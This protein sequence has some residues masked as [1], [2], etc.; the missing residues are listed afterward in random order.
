MR[1]K[2]LTFSVFSILS[3]LFKMFVKS[4]AIL[5]LFC[6]VNASLTFEDH[7]ELFQ[8]FASLFLKIFKCLKLIK[9]VQQKYNKRYTP[10][11]KVY[12]QKV[13]AENVEKVIRHNIEADLGL[14]S[15]RLAV[16]KFADLTS[17]EFSRLYKGYGGVK[18]PAPHVHRAQ[19]IRLPNSVDWREKGLVTE[20]K[21]QEQCGSCWAFSAVASLEGQH[22]KKTGN[23]VSLSE[24]NLVDCSRPEGNQ[25]CNGGLM[26]QAFDYVK[27]NGGI[28]TEQSYPYEGH[29]DK[30]R[31]DPRNRGATLKS[32]V[33][34]ESGNEQ[35]LQEAT[36]TV[37]PIS[38]AIDAG[39]DFQLYRYKF[40]FNSH[41]I[42]EMLSFSGGVYDNPHCGQSLDHGV[43][44]VGYGTDEESGK[45]YY[46]VKNSWGEDWGEQGYIRMSR[47]ANDQ[48][49]I[50]LQASYPI[51]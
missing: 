13:F 19:D 45:Q 40:V 16:N 22:A 34:I 6:V 41:F 35:A 47:N 21:N 49:G 36:A 12:R 38:V 29:D 20:V 2:Q 24:Q 37:G 44:V 28:D 42:T 48:C 27:Q 43:T 8:V 15:H 23:L 25:G 17:E 3:S 10:V 1:C 30:C 50:A 33:D 9:F 18:K 11:E 14:H 46:L 51:V 31:Y 7:F 5:A 26:D 32:Y 4:A 39:F